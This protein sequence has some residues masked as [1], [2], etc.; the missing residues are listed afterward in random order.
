VADALWDGLNPVERGLMVCA[1]EAWGI[2][3]YA[4][5]GA[6]DEGGPPPDEVVAAALLGLVD[7]GWVDVRRLERTAAP[8]GEPGVQYGPPV[9]REVLE[10]LL[11][12]PE[13]WDDPVDPSWAGALAVSRTER[14]AAAVAE[15]RAAE[16]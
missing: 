1:H 12:L 9:P 16:A 6:G 4:C 13:T 3:P 15:Q 10:R 14:W 2:L 7:R 5:A 8:D 11:Q